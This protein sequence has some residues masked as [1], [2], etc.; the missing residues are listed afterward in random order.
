MKIDLAI[1]A[2]EQ[3]CRRVHERDPK[4]LHVEAVDPTTRYVKESNATVY[5]VVL[6]SFYFV[7]LPVHH[8]LCCFGFTVGCVCCVD[9]LITSCAYLVL[10]RLQ[11]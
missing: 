2:S 5:A 6:G 4:R 10:P 1:R 11:F 9:T 3:N 7:F 8:D